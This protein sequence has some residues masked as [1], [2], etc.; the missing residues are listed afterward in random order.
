MKT[1][2]PDGAL[3][4]LLGVKTRSLLFGERK[5]KR[6][7]EN[8]GG[9]SAREIEKTWLFDNLIWMMRERRWMPRLRGA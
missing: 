9:K 7:T 5:S 8:S 1:Y 2:A 6:K 4:P 3:L